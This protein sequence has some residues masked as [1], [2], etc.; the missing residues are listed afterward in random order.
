[1]RKD[2]DSRTQSEEDDPSIDRGL[3][4][5]SAERI[6]RLLQFLIAN[7]CTRKDVFSRLAFYYKIDVAAP[8]EYDRSRRAARMFERDI[9][10]LENQGFE[11]QKIKV[12][13]QLARYHLVRGSGPSATF[14]FTETDV[15][16]LTLIYNLFADPTQHA[17]IDPTQPLPAPVTRNPFAD[18]MLVL[19]DK[20]VMTLPDEQRQKFERGVRKPYVYFDISPVADYLPSRAI[21]DIIVRAISLRQQ[22][23][24]GYTP[25]HR[26][27]DVIFHEHIDPYYI[28]Y[29]EG[30]FYL[31]GYNHKV[32]QILEYRIDRVLIETLKLEPNMID[33]EQR[34]HPTEFTFWIDSKLVKH[35]LSQRWL[36]HT[37]EREEVDL[38][39]NGKERRRV[40]VRASAYNE[41]R[42]IQQLLKYGEQVEIVEPLRLREKM[43]RTVQ[44]MY[45]LYNAT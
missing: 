45:D 4:H 11:I 40:L 6:F 33:V 26:Q 22:V 36:T 29:M 25:T 16:N 7:E 8:E 20:L 14:L 1:M 34:R 15:D 44:S 13:G 31:I 18:D 39:K 10:F 30:H 23:Q 2:E 37:L 38:D 3:K 17:R 35:G 5:E 27:Q 41:W 12:K 9:K 32:N 21:I 28:I 19:I 24:F 42:V 43:R